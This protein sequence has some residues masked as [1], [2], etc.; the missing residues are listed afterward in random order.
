LIVTT[1]ATIPLTKSKHQDLK[2]ELIQLPTGRWQLSA[3]W[4]NGHNGEI[5]HFDERPDETVLE[6]VRLGFQDDY[7]LWKQNWRGNQTASGGFYS[8]TGSTA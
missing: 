2:E 4:D 7:E 3:T 5:I 1:I 8:A 6:L